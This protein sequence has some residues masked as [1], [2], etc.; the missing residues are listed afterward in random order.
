M[1]G[2][3]RKRERE[4]SGVEGAAVERKEGAN[5]KESREKTKCRKMSRKELK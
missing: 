4:R 2:R 1:S 5:K 3:V